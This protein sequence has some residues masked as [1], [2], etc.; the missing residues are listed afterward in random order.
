MFN[1]TIKVAGSIA[2]VVMFLQACASAR[3]CYNDACYAR[4]VASEDAFDKADVA[5]W[6]SEKKSAEQ[7]RLRR[8]EY[9]IRLQDN[10]A[11]SGN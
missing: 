4:K 6:G 7:E 9:R 10:R 3:T 5:A 11:R 1:T 2:L 8:N